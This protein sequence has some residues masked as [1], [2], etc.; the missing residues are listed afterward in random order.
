MASADVAQ[1]L[2]FL[3]VNRILTVDMHNQFTQ[4]YC[5]TGVCME[6]YAA[7]FAGLSHFIRTVED[8]D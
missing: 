5:R 6:N 1:I 7:A 3:G 4:G 8:K 2:E